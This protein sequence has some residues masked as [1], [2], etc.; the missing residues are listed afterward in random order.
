[1]F[2]VVIAVL[3]FQT[4]TQ[5]GPIIFY[6]LSQQATGQY[7]G[8]FMAEHYADWIQNRDADLNILVDEA[9]YLN[10]T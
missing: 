1:M 10:F 2:I 3:V 9:N 8:W 5:K 7:D 4:L 6:N